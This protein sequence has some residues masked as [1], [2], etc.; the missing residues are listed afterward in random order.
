MFTFNALALKE[1][2][3]FERIS[4]VCWGLQGESTKGRG[5]P[6]MTLIFP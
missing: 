4:G 2:G 5:T 1:F 6:M 3:G